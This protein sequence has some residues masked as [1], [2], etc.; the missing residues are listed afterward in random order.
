MKNLKLSII[1]IIGLCLAI[2]TPVRLKA[3]HLEIG[4]FAGYETWGKVYTNLGYLRVSGG[5]NFGG[6]LVLALMKMPSSNSVIT[7]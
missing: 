2:A 5:A 1:I 4:P 3:Q 6:M 7:T